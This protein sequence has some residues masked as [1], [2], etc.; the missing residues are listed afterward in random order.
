MKKIIAL[1]VIFSPAILL[2]SSLMIAPKST[3][4][5]TFCVVP[6]D[7]TTPI[8]NRHVGK[9]GELKL[10]QRIPDR[11]K[12][13]DCT[14]EITISKDSLD[15]GND[16]SIPFSNIESWHIIKDFAVDTDISEYQGNIEINGKDKKGRKVTINYLQ[17]RDR[18]QLEKFSYEMSKAT[19][20]AMGQKR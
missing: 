4:A 13:V 18:N 6:P 14:V 7:Y 3:L 2:I 16:V 10:G 19:G 15:I 20:L 5:G 1:N 9:R 12:T 17:F 8:R 11:Q